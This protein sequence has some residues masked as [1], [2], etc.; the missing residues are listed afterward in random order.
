MFGE[1]ENVYEVLKKDDRLV[2]SDGTLMKN[3][4]YEL[5]SKLDET[6]LQLLLDNEVTKNMFFRNVNGI[7][8]FDS[9]KFNW[10]IDSKEFLPDSYSKYQK[11]I[12]NDA[13]GQIKYI[14][15]FVDDILDLTK[16]NV[17]SAQNQSITIDDNGLLAKRKET[18]VEDGVIHY[19]VHP[20]IVKPR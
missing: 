10:V 7:F 1:F 20:T 5:S 3:R 4:I 9:Q 18:I 11:D 12:I 16:D 15:S 8:V 14:N 13:I 6:F 2:A 17:L 19:G